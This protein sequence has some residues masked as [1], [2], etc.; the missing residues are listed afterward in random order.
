MAIGALEVRLH[1]GQ[2]Q[3]LK[4]K[5]RVV[6]SLIDRLRNRYNLSA[7]EVGGRDSRQESIIEMAIVRHSRREAD[8]S[9]QKI[10]GYIR[11]HPG[12]TL[13]EFELD[14]F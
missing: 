14:F 10:L 4:D 2:A 8:S 12:A 6:R 3:S 11:S 9:L 5:R 1:V 7:A 13:V